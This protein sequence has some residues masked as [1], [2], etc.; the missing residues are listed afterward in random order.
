MGISS[1]LKSA[2]AFAADRFNNSSAGAKIGGTLVSAYMGAVT[3]GVTYLGASQNPDMALRAAGAALGVA[4]LSYLGFKVGDETSREPG[5]LRGAGVNATVVS[6]V[7]G[8]VAY[9]MGKAFKII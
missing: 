5:L 9:G 7:A 4:G 3:A 2:F 6:A 8:G 1:G